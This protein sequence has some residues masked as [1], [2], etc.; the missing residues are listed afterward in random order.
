MYLYQCTENSV[1][2]LYSY[3]FKNL[4][5]YSYF[6]MNSTYYFINKKVVIVVNCIVIIMI[7]ICLILIYFYALN[8]IQN[9]V[10]S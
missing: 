6:S 3:S 4:I 8:L 1:I 7:L 5:I 10:I 2:Y 9:E